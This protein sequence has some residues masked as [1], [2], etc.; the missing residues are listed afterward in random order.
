MAGGLPKALLTRLF[1]TNE[2]ADRENAERLDELVH[3][4]ADARQLCIWLSHDDGYERHVEGCLAPRRLSL[5]IGAQVML[6]KNL[7][8]AAKLVN[9]SRGIVVAFE[10]PSSADRLKGVTMHPPSAPPLVPKVALQLEPDLP[11]AAAVPA[12][13]PDSVMPSPSMRAG[14]LPG[15]PGRGGARL[16]DEARLPRGLD[17]RGGRTA[18]RLA[19][20]GAAQARVVDLGETRQSP[21]PIALA[22]RP[23]P[24]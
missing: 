1:P 3:T 8:Q 17:G 14:R 16:A 19:H 12:P 7:D 13:R 2:R 4:R 18:G 10:T 21:S 23:R 24:R 20:A 6:L 9:G 5:R 11:A 15:R 22:D